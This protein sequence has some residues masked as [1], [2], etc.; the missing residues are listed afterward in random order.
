MNPVER[1][2]QDFHQ[3]HPGTTPLVFSALELPG[4][5]SSYD[6]LAS[7]L[8]STASS[9]SQLLDLGCGDG[10]LLD[11]LARKFPQAQLFGID[12]SPTELKA[13]RI[14]LGQ[15]GTLLNERAQEL[16]LSDDSIDATVSHLSLMLMSDIEKVLQEVHRILVSGGQ[17]SAIVGREFLL[18]ELGPCYLRA[19]RNAAHRDR[20]PTLPLVDPRTHTQSGW[21]RLLEDHFTSLQFEELNLE[22]TPDFDELWESLAYTYDLD[23][24]TPTSQTLMKNELHSA[25]QPLL[26]A[27]GTLVTGWGLLLIQAKAK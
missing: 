2:L 23:R 1:F 4:R 8:H 26:R 14:R 15:T 18:G 27:D 6:I 13:A 20:L 25:T 24:L 16:S 5:G 10:F 12:M 19:F 21:R 11:L 3:R 7:T 9:K 22:W 17:F